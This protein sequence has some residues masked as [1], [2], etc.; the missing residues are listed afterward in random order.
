MKDM[1]KK[2]KALFDF[3]K[4]DGNADLQQVINSVHARYAVANARSSSR[5]LNLDEMEWVAAA[6]KPEQEMKKN[7][8]D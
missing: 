6:G 8:R 3:Q 1:E 2:L 4:F 5:E 7:E